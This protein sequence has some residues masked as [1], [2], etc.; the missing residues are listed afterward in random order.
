MQQSCFANSR[1]YYARRPSVAKDKCLSVAFASQAI[2]RLSSHVMEH[3]IRDKALQQTWVACHVRHPVQLNKLATRGGCV[4]GPGHFV[5]I[6]M[7]TR[8]GRHDLC[9][10]LQ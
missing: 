9:T 7:P 6:E 5:K 10:Y 1:I 3:V 8:G 4:P 2:A